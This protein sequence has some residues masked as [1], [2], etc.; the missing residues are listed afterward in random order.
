MIHLVSKR[1]RRQ[2][3]VLA[4]ITVL[5]FA[6]VPDLVLCV[7]PGGHGE[8]EFSCAGRCA[9][10]TVAIVGNCHDVADAHCIDT[11]IG[12]EPMLRAQADSGDENWARVGSLAGVAIAPPSPL[13][14]SADSAAVWNGECARA[15]SPTLDTFVMRC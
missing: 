9:S 1:G 14:G 7:E 4:T 15:H 5:A 8:I 11:E 13:L 2:F 12:S 6:V 3:A 10:A